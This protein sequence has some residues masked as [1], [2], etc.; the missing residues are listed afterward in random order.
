MNCKSCGKGIYINHGSMEEIL[1]KDC[2]TT[3]YGDS[4]KDGQVN[5]EALRGLGKAI[6]FLGI[7]Y[8]IAQ[9]KAWLIALN[10]G[11]F[12]EAILNTVIGLV[13]IAVGY[14]IPCL[15][16]IERGIS[17]IVKKQTDGGEKSD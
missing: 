4:N 9:I 6:V 1:C 7:L 16:S 15:V 8:I 2:Y 11:G 10:T 13:L 5:Y 17:E 14:L 12:G 3:K